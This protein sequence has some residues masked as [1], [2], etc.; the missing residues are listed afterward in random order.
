MKLN[1][2]FVLMLIWNNRLSESNKISN[3]KNPL[4]FYAAK[5]KRKNQLLEENWK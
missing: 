2:T 4:N 5:M 1:L 3:F